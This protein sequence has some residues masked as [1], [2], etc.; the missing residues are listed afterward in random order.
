MLL[1]EIELIEAEG[2]YCIFNLED[3]KK[4]VISKSLKE[5]EQILPHENFVR[6]H[7]SYLI[8]FNFIK[9]F[10]YKNSDIKLKSG[11]RVPVSRRKKNNFLKMAL[12]TNH[13]ELKKKN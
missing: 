8:N 3:K 10:D 4:I 13:I 9:E 5:Y 6:V 11:K 7:R 12:D 1:S 2:S